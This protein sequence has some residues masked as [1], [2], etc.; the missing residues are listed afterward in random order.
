MPNVVFK[1]VIESDIEQLR[2]WRN[3][4]R[5]QQN[6]LNTNSISIDEQKK[7]F[8]TLA[9]DDT[10][11]QFVCWL[12]DKPIGVLNF[13]AINQ[14]TCE[15]GCYIGSE[16]ILPGFGLVL[17]ACALEYAFNHL[18]VDTLKA[19]VLI[20]NL[21]PQKIHKF[22]KYQ[23]IDDKFIGDDIKSKAV[24]HYEYKKQTWHENKKNVFSLL[25]KHLLNVIK[26]ATFL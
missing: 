8:A 13:T 6:M 1:P 20:N 9:T 16:H 14:H 15:W 21:A 4:P 3:N 26:S 11:K 24:L 5:I 22:F 25:P 19:Q 12:D 7:W 18:Q 23:Y 10:Q 2:L 17:A